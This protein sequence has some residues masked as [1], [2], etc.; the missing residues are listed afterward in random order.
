MKKSFVYALTAAILMSSAFSCEVIYPDNGVEDGTEVT[1]TPEPEPEPDP[2]PG[3]DPTPDPDP[4][5]EPEKPAYYVKVSEELPIR[6][7][8]L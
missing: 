6:Q 7:V 2:E 3:Q 1:P 8:H 4:V 5:P